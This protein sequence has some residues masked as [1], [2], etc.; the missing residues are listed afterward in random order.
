MSNAL[1]EQ[2][3]A[4]ARSPS[5][6]NKYR[7]QRFEDVYGQD[8]PVRYLSGLIKRGRIRRNLL[9][10]GAVGSGKTSLVRLYA[11]AL[12][13][14]APTQSG[15]PCG[16]C[17]WCAAE[18]EDQPGLYEHD[19][20]G[21]DGGGIGDI[22][23][24][25]DE[26][27]RPPSIYRRQVLFFDE[28]HRLEK[29]AADFLLKAVEEPAEGVV[30]CFATTEV[31]KIRP[32]L[33]SRLVDLQ[34]R[35]LPAPLAIDF[36]KTVAAKEGIAC[37]P[38]ALSLLAGLKQGYP[39]D[40][41]TGLDQVHDA[42]AGPVTLER[43]RSVFDVDHTRVLVDYF[44]ALAE[45]DLARQTELIVSWQ[46]PALDKIRWLQAFLTSLYLNDIVGRRVIV[47]AV[48]ASIKAL[49]R[50]P[51]IKGFCHRLNLEE[52]EALARFWRPMMQFWAAPTADL[53]EAANMLRLALFHDFVNEELPR[54]G[55]RPGSTLASTSMRKPAPA[56]M[57]VPS[58]GFAQVS[59]NARPAIPP[60]V[61]DAADADGDAGFLQASDVREI[62]NRASF[63]TQEYG[64]LFNIAFEVVPSLM[65]ADTETEGVKLVQELCAE[66]GEQVAAW[67]G[68][69]V[70]AHL[71]LFEM[72][73]RRV[74][75]P[76][77]RPSAASGGQGPRHRLCRTCRRLA[78]QLAT[79]AAPLAARAR[80]HGHEGAE[81]RRRCGPRV[82]LEQDPGAVRGPRRG[83]RGLG[84]ADRAVG[85][86]A[87]ASGNPPPA[88]AGAGPASSA[89]SR[90][91]QSAAGGDRGGVGQPDGAAVGLRCQGVGRDPD[92][93]GASGVSR[94]ARH[95]KGA[96]GGARRA[97]A[98]AW[99]RYAASPGGG[100][101]A[102]RR[103]AFTAREAAPELA[104][105]VA[106]AGGLTLMLDVDYL[107]QRPPLD[108]PL[109]YR[110]R[111]GVMLPKLRNLIREEA[112][113]KGWLPRTDCH[114]RELLGYGCGSLFDDLPDYDWAQ[115]K[116]DLGQAGIDAALKAL[117]RGEP[118]P[119]MHF[120]P[121]TRLF[122][123]Q[124]RWPEIEEADR[125]ERCIV[126]DEPVITRATPPETLKAVLH[127]LEATTDLAQQP[128][129][130]EQ[131]GFVESFE[132][133][134]DRGDVEL[135]ELMQAF[136]ERVLIATDP[137]TNRFDPQ[138]LC[139]RGARAAGTAFANED[140]AAVPHLPRWAGTP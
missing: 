53:S 74:A 52:P 110:Y 6:A 100:G 111:T 7:P 108:K 3:L 10:H 72:H 48:I 61:E 67:D 50:A 75:R 114:P 80:D 126:I 54:L 86:A 104:R 84:P 125:D 33:R 36:L 30:F 140:G 139:S 64:V 102:G 4:G 8:H 96:R 132:I 66:L 37:E 25:V 63:L 106:R 113:R 47:D 95:Q 65:G 129:L 42:E 91:G 19:V 28:A 133:L 23:S 17:Q 116:S 98:D 18:S 59:L 99:Q 73:R 122:A 49:E 101:A 97:S 11:K 41:L 77:R 13:C 109:I 2:Q 78:A 87:R 1:S 24:R 70:F 117:A 56:S 35:P 39:R 119:S 135:P 26:L 40:L 57:L 137:V 9:L 83:G 21:R 29:D 105:L 92:G 134:I 58:A 51:I 43:V 89:G 131:P 128:E 71:T 118:G 88:S 85:S 60:G 136:D 93:V 138:A 82:S 34:V 15:S 44:M 14:D 124:P 27:N 45:G 127:Y 38:E 107:L 69:G 46:E 121:M 112:N 90:I 22:K 94:P 130:L 76:H 55:E 5:L 68:E 79:G 32:A 20:S 62:I 115:A 12:I 103:L 16:T 81:G 123:R 31:D 120:I